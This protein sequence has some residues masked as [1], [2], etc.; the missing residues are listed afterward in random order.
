MTDAQP[1]KSDLGVRV[2]SAIVMV[3]LA[4]TALWLGGW[5][6]TA[7]VAVIAGIAYTEFVTL[8]RKANSR[9]LALA[10]AA[11]IGAVYV[12][13]AA[14]SLT[15]NNG[16]LVLYVLI[17]VIVT[18]IA[19]YFT[20]RSIGGPKIAPKISPS[21]TWSGLAG[22]MLAAGIWLSIAGIMGSYSIADQGP[23]SPE[24]QPDALRWTGIKFFFLGALLAVAAQLGDFF[25]SWLKRRAGV[26]DSSKLIP[27][28]GGVFDRVDGLIP[29]A[30]IFGLLQLVEQ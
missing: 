9:S 10:A 14:Y 30:I 18:D 8:L 2:A 12:G 15:A 1:K 4:G 23:Q 16:D 25:E 21:K 28:H 17:T 5:V 22:G 3:V 13:F 7:F 24:I 29:V 20:G 11:I 19:A 6:W 27:G 26:K